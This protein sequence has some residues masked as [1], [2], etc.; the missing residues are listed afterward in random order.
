MVAGDRVVFLG[1]YL[2]GPF[3]GFKA[4]GAVDGAFVSGVVEC[5]SV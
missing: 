5:V 3:V 2:E 1:V 4:Y